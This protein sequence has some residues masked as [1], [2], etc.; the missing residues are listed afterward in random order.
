[1]FIKAFK[2]R[3]AELLRHPAGTHVLDD[4]YL[5]ASSTQRNALASEFYGREYSLFGEGTLN[6]TEGAPVSLSTLLSAV[7]ASKRR[8]IIQHLAKAIYPVIEKGLV[9]CQLAH[10][11]VAE[12]LE[13]GP[14]SLVVDA[15]E[16]LSGEALLHMLHTHDGVKAACMVFAYGT[17]KD[18]K[19]ALKAMKGHVAAAVMDEWGHLAILTA[20]SVTDDTQMLRKSVVAE[21]LQV[22]VYVLCFVVC[23]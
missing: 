18:R 23:I 6:N 1:M 22:R 16:T 19:K 17:A 2:G 10:R 20:L 7:D 9:D 11:L 3:A 14:A 4:L 12:Y 21:I 13:A 15:V 5:A 8:S